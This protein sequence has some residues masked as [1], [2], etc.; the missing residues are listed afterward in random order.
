MA[1]FR[2]SF[3]LILCKP[4]F[5]AECRQHALH[6]VRSHMHIHTV[7]LPLC[8]ASS[9]RSG[10]KNT[11]IQTFVPYINMNMLSI[12]FSIPVAKWKSSRIMRYFT[13]IKS[14]DTHSMW[15]GGGV[16]QWWNVPSLTFT[17]IK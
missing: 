3:V 17:L 16:L 12:N 6:G 7:H 1:S 8:P 2:F 14:V 5:C 4:I 9:P 10:P 15:E 11:F 13:R